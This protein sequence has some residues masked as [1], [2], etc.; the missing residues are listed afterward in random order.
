MITLDLPQGS[1]DWIIARLWRLTASKLDPIILPS[2][3]LSQSKAAIKAID[4]MIAGL[5][6]ANRL[7]QNPHLLDDLDDRELV[8]LLAQ[9]TGE[10][11]AGNRHTQRGHDCEPDAIA[12]L[13]EKIGCQVQPVGMV[14]MGDDPNGVV[15]CSP[16]GLIYGSVSRIKAGAEIKSPCLCNFYGH[17]VD[18]VLPAE[19]ELQVHAGMAIC[20]VDLWHFASYFAGKPLFHVEVKRSAFTD[21]LKESLESFKDLYR[22]RYDVVH[23]AILNVEAIHGEKGATK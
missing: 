9:Y 20:E 7:I 19:Y 8:F 14:V 11:F 13:S 4:K 21:T 2:G 1:I 22:D 5:E 3:K 17:A 6:L 12:A 23:R 10:K 18:G 15:S 16:D